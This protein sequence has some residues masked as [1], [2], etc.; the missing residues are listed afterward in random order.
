MGGRRRALAAHGERRL[1][2]PCATGHPQSLPLSAHIVLARGSGEHRPWMFGDDALQ[3]YRSFAY[4]H[5]EL[6]PFFHTEGADAFDAEPGALVARQANTERRVLMRSRDHTAERPVM[7]YQGKCFYD[8]E[9][10]PWPDV[11]P[12][13]WKLASDIFVAPIVTNSTTR[14]VTFPDAG[15]TW[16]NWF[17]GGE[18]DGCARLTYR[19]CSSFSLCG[20]LTCEAAF[21]GS[22]HQITAGL[23]TIPLY[24]RA[25]STIPL[26][27]RNDLHG[28]YYGQAPRALTFLMTRPF[29][30]T[31]AH[32]A[33]GMRALCCLLP[34]NADG[35]MPLK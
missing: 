10:K 31:T 33:I 3:I 35:R 20:S 14:S 1:V 29:G 22:T 28:H 21:S 24:L 4:L 11:C 7:F 15:E 32:D 34:V 16:V 27:V 8:G 9:T 26:R 18:Y 13:A 19:I 2:R 25:G 5:E 30:A 17:D 12:Y 23:D 6:R